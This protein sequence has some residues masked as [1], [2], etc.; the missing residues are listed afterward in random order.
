LRQ[1]FINLL[2]RPFVGLATTLDF[3]NAPSGSVPGAVEDGRR[4]RPVQKKKKKK[5]V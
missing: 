2:R 3:F 5:T 4:L 1:E